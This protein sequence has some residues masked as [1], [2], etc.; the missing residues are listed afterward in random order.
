MN[1][2]ITS[3]EAALRQ[4]FDA[5]DGRKKN[6]SEVD[7]LFDVVSH[8]KYTLVMDGKTFD[9][10]MAKDIDAGYLTRGSK[11]DVI[12]L[13]RIDAD[14]IDVQI[15]AQSEVECKNI[16]VVYTIEDNKVAKAQVIDN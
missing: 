13:R 1:T 4:Y 2:E 16:H 3:C 9:R 14:R 11:V 12:D 6:F 7:E 5:F 10:K 15:R 8:E